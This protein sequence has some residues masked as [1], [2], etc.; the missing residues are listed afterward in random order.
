MEERK[1]VEK[2]EFKV[3]GLKY[4]GKNEQ[5]EIPAMWGQFMGRYGEISK[6][7]I[8][9]GCNVWGVCIAS[10]DYKCGDDFNYLAAVEV[11]TDTP[12][13]SGMETQVV[14][15]GKWMVFEH[16]GALDTLHQ[17]YDAIHSKLLP[18]SGMKFEMTELELYDERFKM[19]SPDSVME[20]WV[21]IKE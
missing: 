2:G 14:P 17:T 9:G 7:S 16:R 3:V 12:A 8:L 11:K 20:I 21:K 6:E 18:E 5:G 1:I 15:A 10:E 19:G 4:R 13:P